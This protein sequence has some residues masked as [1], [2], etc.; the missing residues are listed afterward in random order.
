MNEFIKQHIADDVQ[1][2]RLKY[3]SDRNLS[4]AERRAYSDAILQIECRRKYSSKFPSLLSE[5]D[6][7][8]PDSLSAEQA[9]HEWVAAYH[10][11]L[12]GDAKS[13]V[14]ITSGLGIDFIFMSRSVA[15]NGGGSLAVDMDPA[16]VD[17]LRS[18]AALAGLDS[19]TV[20]YG[21]SMSCLNSIVSGECDFE[22]PFSLPADI[23]FVDPARR[24]EGDRRL[25]DP[26]QCSPDI[27][28][29]ADLVFNVARREIIK[30][31]PMLDLHEAL[32]IFRGVEEIHVVSVRNECKEVLVIVSPEGRFSKVRCVNIMSESEW[33]VVDVSADS[34]SNPV[35]APFI[36]DMDSF[37]DMISSDSPA[38]LYEPN[39]SIMKAGV[40]SA[41][42]M[43]YTS[44]S[45][46]EES[47]L[48]KLSANCHLFIGKVLLPDYPGRIIRIDG[49][50]DKKM[51]K[52]LKGNSFNVVSR[53]YPQKADAIASALKVKPSDINY[54]YGV[55]VGKKSTPA[56]LYGASVG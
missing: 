42:S 14:D 48:Y 31:S 25:Y 6:F 24:G 13:L 54:I 52:S 7:R 34:F 22:L 39:A 21:E 35:P 3:C 10:A 29:N 1:K 33:S 15:L 2:L 9:S 27:I 43:S 28:S 55:T 20:L 23:L 32:R 12:V 37:A 44:D 50:I 56:L 8:F 5:D 41:I 26:A 38:Y 30:N 4:E 47:Q 40:A 18:N 11:S 45:A 16:K 36:A 53:N 46:D 51:K 17:C 49:L 19:F